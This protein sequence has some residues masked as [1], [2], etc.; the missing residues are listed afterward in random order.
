MILSLPLAVST[1]NPLHLLIQC[2]DENAIITK[3]L[4]TNSLP[5]V[6][7]V[8][9]TIVPAPLTPTTSN[10]LSYAALG[11]RGTNVPAPLTPTGHTEPGNDFHVCKENIPKCL[12]TNF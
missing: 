12:E 1:V 7:G 3:C 8:R 5:L 9:G 10:D 6:L 2:G 4:E 11:V